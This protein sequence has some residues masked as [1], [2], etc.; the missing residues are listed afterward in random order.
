MMLMKTMLQTSLLSV[1]LLGA[2]VA[3]AQDKPTTTVN[4]RPK[5]IPRQPIKIAPP[6]EKPANT[7]PVTGNRPELARSDELRQLIERFQ[8][9]R[10]NY[11]L[12]QKELMQQIDGAT[13]DQ[14]EELR[15]KLRES[16]DQWREM[17]A[18][19]RTQLKDRAQELRDRLS[20]ELGRVVDGGREEGGGTRP[21]N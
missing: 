3:A 13:E 7:A 10:R 6:E 14:R 12:Q 9:A 21:R 11:L 20:S 8:A 19:F 15:D 2:G 17:Q 18:E 1:F 4:E 16:L 5:P